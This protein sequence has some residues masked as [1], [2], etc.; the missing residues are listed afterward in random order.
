MY[1]RILFLFLLASYAVNS[2]AQIYADLSLTKSGINNS[3]E[4]SIAVSSNDPA[5]VCIA[6][7]NDQIYTSNDTGHTWERSTL[8]SSHGVYGD[9]VLLPAPDG[10]IY[11]THL[12]RTEGKEW[13]EWFDRI[14]VQWSDD[15]GKTWS[16][17]AGVGYNNDKTQ[18]KPWLS[19]DDTKSKFN[20]N[21]YLTWTEFDVYGSKNP[22][23]HSRIRFS[24][25]ED[26]GNTWSEPIT[27]S[28]RDGDCLDDDN[29]VEGANIAIDQNGTLY[30]VWSGFDSIYLDIS[31]DGGITWQKDKV[32]ATQAGG[33]SRTIDNL[34]RGNGMPFIVCDQKGSLWVTYAADVDGLSRVAVIRSTDNGATWT[35]PVYTEESG[36][37]LM[38]NISVD[39][40]SATTYVLFYHSDTGKIEKNFMETRLLVIKWSEDNNLQK[41]TYVVEPPFATPGEKI[42]FGDYLHSTIQHGH[43]Q[44]VYAAN[45]QF[46]ISVRYLQYSLFS[47]ISGD[48]MMRIS[49]PPEG[50]SFVERDNSLIIRL[51]YIPK[52]KIKVVCKNGFLQRTVYKRNFSEDCPCDDI[53][54]NTSV[55]IALGGKKCRYKIHSKV[56]DRELDDYIVRK[57]K[58]TTKL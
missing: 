1:R 7:N 41:E 50:L 6:T 28:E 39:K 55:S 56:F 13:G 48:E 25:S 5:K 31:R 10:R 33:W 46:D 21:L 58:G 42:F 17:G 34:Y 43:I 47:Q 12:S 53:L 38:P 30:C 3:N 49:L 8:T 52:A 4:P 27:I 51:H 20:G 22:E 24:S 40:S 2:S 54:I 35:A 57:I 44:M 32:I 19:I 37:Q 23:H 14:V 45:S 29:T 36:N 11:I 16:D 26:G 15:A 18:D 9:P